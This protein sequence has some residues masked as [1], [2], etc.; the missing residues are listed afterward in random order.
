MDTALIKIGHLKSFMRKRAAETIENLQLTGQNL[1]QVFSSKS[2]CP[3]A[4]HFIPFEA[5]QPNLN[6]KTWSKQLISC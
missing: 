3:R 2:G 4:M 6:L 1:G 5:K